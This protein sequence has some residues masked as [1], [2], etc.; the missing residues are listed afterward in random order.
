MYVDA[1]VHIYTREGQQPRAPKKVTGFRKEAERKISTR[2]EHPI[3]FHKIFKKFGGFIDE[4]LKSLVF[5]LR[6]FDLGF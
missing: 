6:Q 1:C 5:Y 2:L 4:N 3:F